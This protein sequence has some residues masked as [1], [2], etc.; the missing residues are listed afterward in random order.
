MSSNVGI[1]MGYWRARRRGARPPQPPPNTTAR[2]TTVLVT[3]VPMTSIR[4]SV[5]DRARFDSTRAFTLLALYQEWR[6]ANIVDG[7]VD[8]SAANR[9]FNCHA[10]LP[11]AALQDDQGFQLRLVKQAVH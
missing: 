2:T 4:N 11:P 9:R 10:R 7:G 8:Q 6:P 5:R 3:T 1:T